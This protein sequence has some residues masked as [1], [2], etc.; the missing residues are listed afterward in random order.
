MLGTQ[1][2][3][4]FR[5]DTIPDRQLDV[6]EPEN[7]TKIIVDIYDIFSMSP[8]TLQGADRLSAHTGAIVLVPDFFDGKRLSADVIPTD[9]EEKKQQL[10]EFFSSVASFDIN[11]PK[12]LAIRKAIS[13]RFPKA[14]DHCGVFGLCWGGKMAVLAC[15]D[16]NEGAGRR[17]NASGTAHPG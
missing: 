9:T 1:N 3:N 6:I 12:L 17:F 4:V 11:L 7:A 13:V 10:Q 5:Q 8:Q 15:G 2:H 14:E 16:G